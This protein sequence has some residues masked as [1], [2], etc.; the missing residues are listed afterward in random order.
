MKPYTKDIKLRPGM[1]IKCEYEKQFEYLLVGD[2]NE[3][4][5]VCDDCKSSSEI[6]A[7]DDSLCDVVSD[8]I[9]ELKH[10]S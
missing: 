1:I 8:K 4:L 6:V 7:Y 10:E 5:G 9:T 2:V 3:L